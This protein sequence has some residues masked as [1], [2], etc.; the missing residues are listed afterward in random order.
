MASSPSCRALSPASRNACAP[1]ELAPITPGAQPYCSHNCSHA[2]MAC[3]QDFG[4]PTGSPLARQTP[5]STR[6]VTAA[7]PLAANTTDLSRRVAK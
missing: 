2:A 3:G 5:I 6:Y 7:R 1:V 4:S